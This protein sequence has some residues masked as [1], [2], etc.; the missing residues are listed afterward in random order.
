MT[1]R[2]RSLLVV[3]SLGVCGDDAP[4]FFTAGDTAPDAVGTVNPAAD[5][6]AD[7]AAGGLGPAGTTAVRSFSL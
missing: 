3:P 4:V 2:S 5:S 1:R 6:V 7:P